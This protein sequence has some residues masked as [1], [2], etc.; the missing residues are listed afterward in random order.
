MQ[1]V[2]ALQFLETQSSMDCTNEQSLD[3]HTC[4][5]VTWVTKKLLVTLQSWTERCTN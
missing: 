2:G 4:P 1:Q 5:V 3:E